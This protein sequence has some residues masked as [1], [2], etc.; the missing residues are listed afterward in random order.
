MDVLCT[1]KTGT[2]TEG[3]VN[4][5]GYFD[6]HGKVNPRVLELSLFCN[7]AIIHHKV[8]GNAI[9]VALWEYALKHQFSCPKNP[10]KLADEPFDYDRKAMYTV[11]EEGGVRTLIV[12]GAP[13]NILRL[14]RANSY[15]RTLHSRLLDLNLDG[16]R[17]VA[18]AT[19]KVR[20]KA[21]YSWD[22]V[23]GLDFVGYVTFLDIPKKSAKDAIDKLRSLSVVTKI[24]TGDNEIVTGKVCREIGLSFNRVL[25]GSQITKLTNTELQTQVQEIDIFA[26]VTPEQKLRIIEAFQKSGHTVGYLGDGINDLPSLHS[27]DVGISVNSAV[28]VAKDAAAIVLLRKGLDVI[29]DGI[30]EGRK[31]FSNTM[32]YILMTTSSNFGNMFSAAG[33]SFFLPFLPMTP[34]QILVTNGLYDL[35]QTSIPSDN[36]DPES[37]IRPRHW[38]IHFICQY[39]IFFGPLSSIFDFATY[40]VMIFV[41]HAR[42]ALFQTGWF[43]ESIATEILIVFVIRT[44]RSPFFKSRPS[45]WLLWA[46]LG[47]AAVGLILPLSPLASSLGFVVPPPLY[48]LILICMVTTYLALVETVKS[49]FLKKSITPRQRPRGMVGNMTLG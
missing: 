24:V 49:R 15:P 13:D 5:T 3:R 27:A 4:V 21:E 34:V 31:T 18:V 48:F 6:E 9:D 42:S 35:S 10:H 1:D 46:C 33:A 7:T 16:L 32:K 8:L 40:A 23:E 47:L 26:R 17:M 14:C 2:L 36:V 43:I 22:D 28:D 41:F 45:P 39:M 37:L 12:K 38:D 29:A 30:T 11:I 25:L 20:A 19:K 44:S